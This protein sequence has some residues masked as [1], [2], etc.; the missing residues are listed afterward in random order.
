MMMRISDPATAITDYLLAIESFVFAFALFQHQ[1]G[2]WSVLLWALAFVMLMISAG[3]GGVY[4]HLRLDLSDRAKQWFWKATALPM[5]AALTLFLCGGIYASIT[6]PWKWILILAIGAGVSTAFV[7]FKSSS[8]EGSG[9]KRTVIILVIALIV[10]LGLLLQQWLSNGAGSGINILLGSNLCV[11]GTLVQ[12]LAP[13]I[14]RRFNH[15]DVCHIFFM[16]G[17]YFLFA[18]GL[19]LKDK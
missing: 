10:L 11:A 1:N 2:Q 14:H 15:N 7:L 6:A 17:L 4:H 12:Q 16:I 5:T 8:N 19:L 13:K 9:I 18:G 3:A